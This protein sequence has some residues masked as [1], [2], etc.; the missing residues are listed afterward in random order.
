[1][2]NTFSVLTWNSSSGSWS[3]VRCTCVFCQN[4]LKFW[5]IYFIVTI[6]NVRNQQGMLML[7]V[8]FAFHIWK[9]MNFFPFTWNIQNQTHLILQWGKKKSQTLHFC[10][11]RAKLFDLTIKSQFPQFQNYGLQDPTWC[12][13]SEAL[14]SRI[15]I[16]L[17]KHSVF[18][19]EYKQIKLK[20]FLLL[21]KPW[22]LLRA[23]PALQHLFFPPQVHCYLED[24]FFRLSSRGPLLRGPLLKPHC[25]TG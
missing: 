19:P 18:F 13:S 5:C 23:H 2:Q 24:F 3:R 16:P 4:M 6:L 9:S 17:P 21:I 12:W 20:R 25:S 8:C 11:S 1:M 10:D 15:T 7:M 22:G 14:L